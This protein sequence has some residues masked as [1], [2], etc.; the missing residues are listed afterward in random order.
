[1]AVNPPK[2]LFAPLVEEIPPLPTVTGISPL[3]ERVVWI[4]PPPPAPPPPEQPPPPP[5]TTRTDA[6]ESEPVAT[7]DD[8]PRN[9]WTA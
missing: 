3:R 5:A 4:A 6:P 1:M 9:L 2:V 8:E 7:N